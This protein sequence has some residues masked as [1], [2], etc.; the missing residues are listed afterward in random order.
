MATRQLTGL[1][2]CVAWNKISGTLNVTGLD[3]TPH[4]EEF[5]S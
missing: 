3:N 1:T 5:L 4:V 2:R